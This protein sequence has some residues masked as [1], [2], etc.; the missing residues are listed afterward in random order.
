MS[1]SFEILRNVD[2]NNGKT[3]LTLGKLVVKKIHV[4]QTIGHLTIIVQVFLIIIV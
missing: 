4:S 3:L 2:D 1:T